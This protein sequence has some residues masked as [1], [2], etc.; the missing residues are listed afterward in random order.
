VKEPA[1]T[2]VHCARSPVRYSLCKSLW[3]G[4]PW[5][6]SLKY[7][8]DSYR[9]WF[10]LTRK[11]AFLG[12]VVCRYRHFAVYRVHYFAPDNLLGTSFTRPN[13]SVTQLGS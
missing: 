7:L 12:N 1:C 3:K 4:C 8:T 5:L 13:G 11:H 6:P 10:Y 2:T 9:R